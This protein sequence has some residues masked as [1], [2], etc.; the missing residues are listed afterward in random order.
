MLPSRQIWLFRRSFAAMATTSNT[1][2]E[3]LIRSKVA[4]LDHEGES[5]LHVQITDALQPTTLEIFND[6]AAHSHHQAMEGSTSK[7]TH[8]RYGQTRH[9]YLRRLVLSSS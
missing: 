1:P 4:I 5:C 7:E 6:S 2:V 3:D 9:Y 8:F